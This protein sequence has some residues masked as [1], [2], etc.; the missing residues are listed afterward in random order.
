MFRS[1]DTNDKI[2]EVASG[3][4]EADWDDHKRAEPSDTSEPDE[5]F[6]IISGSSRTVSDI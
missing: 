2:Y 6:T 3:G 1:N 5:E 4:S